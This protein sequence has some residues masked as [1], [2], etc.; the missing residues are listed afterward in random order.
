MLVVG[1]GALPVEGVEPSPR[2]APRCPACDAVCLPST[3]AGAVART[4]AAV[5]IPACPSRARTR[6]VEGASAVTTASAPAVTPAR[7]PASEA[8]RMD[9]AGRPAATRGRDN[10]DVL[11]HRR[12]PGRDDGNAAGAR[13]RGRQKNDYQPGQS[14]SSH[15]VTN[16]LN[17][18]DARFLTSLRSATKAGPRVTGGRVDRIRTSVRATG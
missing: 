8:A 6:A 1:G 10:L 5:W 2:R 9:V 14:R 7:R 15:L 16:P 17:I 3:P 4:I 12:V 13:R 11:I 18:R